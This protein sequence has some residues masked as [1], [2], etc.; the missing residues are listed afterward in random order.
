MGAS[1]SA[2]AMRSNIPPLVG[3]ASVL[4]SFGLLSFV[5]FGAVQGQEQPE[6]VPVPTGA[7]PL[8]EFGPEDLPTTPM[9]TFQVTRKDLLADVAID[10]SRAAPRLVIRAT[11]PLP[12][13]ATIEV[14]PMSETVMDADGITG[15][16]YPVG[17]THMI[18]VSEQAAA[19]ETDLSADM[20][21]PADLD[22]LSVIVRVARDGGVVQSNILR[23]AAAEARCEVSS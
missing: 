12:A 15:R 13:G 6:E 1:D 4:L 20:L 21:A 16:R 22:T 18:T 3:T 14:K 5:I 2:A 9:H 10:C 23:V 11:E 17:D 8:E 7:H 19:V